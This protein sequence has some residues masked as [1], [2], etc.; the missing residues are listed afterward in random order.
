MGENPETFN[1][2]YLYRGVDEITKHFKDK[3]ICICFSEKIN[4]S[5]HDECVRQYDEIN[6]LISFKY[7]VDYNYT[8]IILLYSQPV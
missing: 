5:K 1:N 4:N 2:N 7:N 8:Q 3:E 6:E